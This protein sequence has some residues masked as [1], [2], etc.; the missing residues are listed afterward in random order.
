MAALLATALITASCGSDSDSSTTDSAATTS[1]TTE[2]APDTTAAPDT[3]EPADTTPDTT[4]ASEPEVTAAEL[5]ARGPYDVARHHPQLPKGG[6]AEVWSPADE[7]AAG[8]TAVDSVRD[9]L[10]SVVGTS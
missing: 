9:F 6:L 5:A 4:A 1:T 7:S 10:P 8:G 2:V 3:A